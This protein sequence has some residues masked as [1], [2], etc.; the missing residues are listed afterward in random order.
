[1]PQ[2]IVVTGQ[3]ATGKTKLAAKLSKEKQ[4]DLINFDSRQ[5]YRSLDIITG[6]DKNLLAKKRV[7]IHL[8]DIVDPKEY[9]SSYH[10]QKLATPLI[11]KLIKKGR[12]PIL[13]GGTYLYLSNLLYG[14]SS[15]GIE[16]DWRLRS[17]LEKKTVGELQNILEKLSPGLFESLNQSDRNNPRRLIRK[18]EIVKKSSK[19]KLSRPDKSGL[20]M[21][22]E[23]Q[24]IGLRFTNKQKLTEAIHKRVDDRIKN[25]AFEEVEKL[26]NKGSEPT[27]FG[28]KTIGYRQLIPFFKGKTSKKEAVRSWITKEIQYAKK[29]YTFMKKDKNVQWTDV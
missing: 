13:V 22:Y 19:N 15:K 1:M 12:T 20:A 21:T 29:Q 3:T 23:V 28:L 27:D 7:R 4:G 16:A 25:G 9:F 26:L 11:E 17:Q 2:I 5:I 10:F 18:I 24:I 6:K 14:L 8:Y